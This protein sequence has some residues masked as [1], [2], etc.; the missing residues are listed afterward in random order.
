M[1]KSTW[2]YT[3]TFIKVDDEVT[4]RAH[5]REVKKSRAEFFLYELIHILCRKKE[6]EKNRTNQE[7]FL[8]K[9]QYIYIYISIILRIYTFS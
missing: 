1:Q 2:S 9:F 3:C 8:C 6:S 7:L 4:K 5:I